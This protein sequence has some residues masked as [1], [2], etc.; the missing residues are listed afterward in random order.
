MCSC[1]V[2]GTGAICK[3][4][5]AVAEATMTALP[6]LFVTTHA[7]RRLLAEVALGEMNVPQD[8]FRELV[9]PEPVP[10]T[11]HSSP[12]ESAGGS[13][14]T[15]VVELT[16]SRTSPAAEM[17]DAD[18]FDDFVMPPPRTSKVVIPTSIMNELQS[19]LETSLQE[20]SNEETLEALS[21]FMK[22]LKNVRNPSSLNSF[23]YTAGCTLG[24][25]RGHSRGKIPVQPTSTER[26]R[27]GMPRGA[28]TVGRGRPPTLGPAKKLKR[29][30]NL[31]LNIR[32]NVRS[33]K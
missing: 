25:R 6:Q 17:S 18:D 32:D 10:T 20:H 28:S 7:N 27:A 24:A 3:H 23:L 22:R 1:V 11:S 8:F 19:T 31:A 29:K 33:A 15:P 26:R 4:Q 30:H 21:K 12:D 5:I 14:T 9:E 16:E 13:S 2:G